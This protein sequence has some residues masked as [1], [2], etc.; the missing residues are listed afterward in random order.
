VA[1]SSPQRASSEALRVRLRGPSTEFECRCFAASAPLFAPELEV[2]VFERLEQASAKILQV[3]EPHPPP[4]TATARMT[5][6]PAQ[7]LGG[8]RS[9]TVSY[10]TR[11]EL[12]A[13][14][15]DATGAIHS[16]FAVCN[17]TNESCT[18]ALST[19]RFQSGIGAR[20]APGGA[21]SV[22]LLAARNPSLT[23]GL[24]LLT[25][26]LLSLAV[27]ALRPLRTNR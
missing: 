12:D 24:A 20:Q 16:C 10:G 26:T 11:L 2:F 15:F 18:Q 1:L 7:D 9:R 25:A 8:G 19:F 21:E 17:G 5:R 3:V 14:G 13:Y 22:G 23:V 6:T 4:N 27:V